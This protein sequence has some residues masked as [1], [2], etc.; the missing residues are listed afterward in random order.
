MSKSNDRASE[1]EVIEI[2][3]QNKKLT[4]DDICRG[5][6]RMQLFLHDALKFMKKFGVYE[7]FI[8]RYTQSTQKIMNDTL[9]TIV[10]G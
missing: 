6:L 3:K 7:E 1:N 9:T 8:S 2:L 10:R 5:Y 4:F